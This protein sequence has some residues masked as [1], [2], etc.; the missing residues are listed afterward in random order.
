MFIRTANDQ[1]KRYCTLWYLPLH[2]QQAW[3]QSKN[4]ASKRLSGFAKFKWYKQAAKTQQ[5]RLKTFIK[6]LKAKSKVWS[7]KILLIWGGR[8]GWA[9]G[10]ASYIM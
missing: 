1:V 5:L 3:F 7:W 9:G 6:N 10:L 4:A 2:T 8:G